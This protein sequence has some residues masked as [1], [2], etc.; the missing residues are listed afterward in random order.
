MDLNGYIGPWY[1]QYSSRE[2]TRSPV[3]GGDRT[4]LQV[5]NLVFMSG[6]FRTTYSNSGL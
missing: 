4:N 1:R 2:V 6:T 5:I 3:I